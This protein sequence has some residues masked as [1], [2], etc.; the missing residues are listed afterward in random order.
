MELI[1]IIVV[2]ATLVGFSLILVAALAAK[3]KGVSSAPVVTQRLDFERFERMCCNLLYA[4]KLE[5]DEISSTGLKELHI[6]ARNPTPITGG[7]LLVQCYLLD[8]TEV[9]EAAQVIEFSNLIIQDRASKGILITT[10]Q[11][12][13]ELATISELAPIEFVDGIQLAELVEKYHV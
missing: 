3:N 12:T 11:F 1:L 2:G 13:K 5:I 4:L 6:V 8:K 7:V 10:G 9:V